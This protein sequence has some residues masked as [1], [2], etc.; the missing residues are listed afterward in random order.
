VV[1]LGQQLL[2]IQQG[3]QALMKFAL[4]DLGQIPDQFLKVHQLTPC[5]LQVL[6]AGVQLGS[7]GIQLQP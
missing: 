2:L 1:V 6:L 3:L 5:P 4:E 7:G